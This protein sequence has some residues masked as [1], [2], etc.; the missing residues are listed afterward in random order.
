[1]LITN[2]EWLRSCYEKGAFKDAGIPGVFISYLCIV[3]CSGCR[4]I[5]SEG[6][7]QSVREFISLETSDRPEEGKIS[8]GIL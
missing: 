5:F 7:L 1:M 8:R 6:L 4:R 3:C 2:N